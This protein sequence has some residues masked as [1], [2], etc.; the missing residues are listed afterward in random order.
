MWSWLGVVPEHHG[1]MVRY[2]QVEVEMFRL[3]G[4]MSRFDV[5]PNL[6]EPQNRFVEYRTDREGVALPRPEPRLS[7]E[8]LCTSH[9]QHLK[10]QNTS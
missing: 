2:V 8:G 3:H 10:A 7:G 5:E 1:G 6:I 4:A 9:P